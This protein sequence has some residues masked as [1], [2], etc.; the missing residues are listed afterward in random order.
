[1][2]WRNP[3]GRVCTFGLTVIAKKWWVTQYPIK[4]SLQFRYVAELVF[5]PMS[6]E[7]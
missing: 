7:F 6:V 1:M 5:N 3:F 4:P 2:Q